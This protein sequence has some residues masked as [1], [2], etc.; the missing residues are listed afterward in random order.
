MISVGNVRVNR[1]GSGLTR[2]VVLNACW[3]YGRSQEYQLMAVLVLPYKKNVLV[4]AGLLSCL[5]PLPVLLTGVSTPLLFRVKVSSPL[6][7]H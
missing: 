7:R 5:H 4:E 1:L 3:Q 2:L 6:T